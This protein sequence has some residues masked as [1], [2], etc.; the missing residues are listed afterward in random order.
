MNL[1]K[2]RG[3][4]DGICGGVVVVLFVCSTCFVSLLFGSLFV[5]PVLACVGAAGAAAA[6]CG[7]AFAASCTAAAAAADGGNGISCTLVTS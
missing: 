7:V 3:S 2:L 5:I 1:S 4:T 6:A